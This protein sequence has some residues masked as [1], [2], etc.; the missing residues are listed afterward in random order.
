[1]TK[2][3]LAEIKL[4]KLRLAEVTDNRQQLLDAN[5]RL[6]VEYDRLV[7]DHQRDLSECKTLLDE[8]T[9]RLSQIYRISSGK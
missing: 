1:M 5:I 8:A 6:T 7:R 4:L 3:L 2:K 9:S